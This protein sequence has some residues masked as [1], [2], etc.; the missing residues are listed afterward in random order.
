M[1]KVYIFVSS[2]F[3]LFGASTNLLAK[4]GYVDINSYIVLGVCLGVGCFYISDERYYKS[5]K[6]RGLLVRVLL[7]IPISLMLYYTKFNF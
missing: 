1:L 3:L 4:F 7:F 6:N 5:V 2:V